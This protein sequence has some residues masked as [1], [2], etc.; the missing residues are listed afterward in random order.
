MKRRVLSLAITMVLVM[1][2]VQGAAASV[3]Y[4]KESD[5]EHIHVDD[6]P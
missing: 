2:L 3:V 6:F 4:G 1:S 5:T